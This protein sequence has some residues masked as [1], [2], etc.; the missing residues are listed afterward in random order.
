MW[1]RIYLIPALQAEEDRD[2][3][4]RY[5]ADKAREKEL[6]G[7]ET[8]VYNTDRHDGMPLVLQC[9]WL[10]RHQI[11]TADVCCNT[12]E[13]AEVGDGIRLGQQQGRN[14]TYT[15]YYKTLQPELGASMCATIRNALLFPASMLIKVSFLDLYSINDWLM[16]GH[17]QNA[18]Q[19]SSYD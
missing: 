1:A 19:M 3:V 11:R 18:L 8:K 13:R 9:A 14:C 12:R 5:L 10:T 2:Q 4:R 15:A 6:L 17:V 7:T 16:R